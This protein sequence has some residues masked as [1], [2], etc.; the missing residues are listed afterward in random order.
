[1]IRDAIVAIGKK[2]EAEL[3]CRSLI[4][5][6][7]QDG[8]TAFQRCCEGLYAS[9]SPAAAPP[10]NAFQRLEQGSDRWKALIGVRYEDILSKDEFATIKTLFQKRH[11]L[12]H[13]D[14]LLT[15]A[16]SRSLVILHTKSV[17][18]SQ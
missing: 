10:M 4:E 16:T 11:L 7:L 14:E 18:G 5:S 17:S 15:I 2:D 9:K 8:V 6:C 3:T 13:S 12:A 1:M